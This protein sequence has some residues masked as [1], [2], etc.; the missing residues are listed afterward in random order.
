M[1]D[2]Y[3][4]TYRGYL[5]DHHSPDPPVVNFDK[6]NAEECERFL[7]EANIDH[8][9]VYTKD[10]WGNSYY[11]TKVGKKH[12]ALGERDW[13][14][15]IKP[16]LEK[17]NIEFTAY[18]CFEYDSY[19][20]KAHPEW[21][22]M[23]KDGQK[24]V[25]GMPDN[26]SNA[27]WGMPC[28]SSDYRKYALEQLKEVVRNYHPDSLFIDIFGKSLCYC[29]TC[30]KRY[31]ERFGMEMPETEEDMIRY[32]KDLAAFLD[33]DS[34]ELL[35]EVK[36]ELKAIDPSLA[37]TVNFSSHYRKS[38]RDKLDY[39]YTEPWAGNWLSGAYTRDTSGGRHP[40]LGPGNVSQ[41]FNYQP[42]SIYELAAA[43]IAAQD[44][45]VFMY[46]ES[47]RR[48]GS[49][50]FEEARK[51]GKTYREIEKIEPY[52]G[53]R[54]VHADVCILQSDLSDTLKVTKSIPIRSVSRTKISGKHREALLG[55][56]KLCDYSKISWC[57]VPE[58]DLDLNKMKEFKAVIIPSVAYISEDMAKDLERYTHEGGVVLI[59]GESGLS[60]A[61]G[62]E[63]EEF[64]LKD[65]MGLA[66]ERRNDDYIQNP[67][68]AYIQPKTSPVWKHSSETTPPINGTVLNCQLT[69]PSNM[70]LHG[71]FINPAVG[72]SDTM[73]V[74][75]GSP[76]PGED[77]GYPAIAE[78]VVGD[79]K[80][81]SFCFDFFALINENFIWTKKML[82]DLLLYLFKPSVFLSTEYVNMAEYALYEKTAENEGQQEWIFHELSA[83]ARLTGGDT[84]LIPGGELQI[85]GA[86]I[87]LEK[88]FQVFP[89]KQEI[90]FTVDEENKYHI[91]LNPLRIHRVYQL[92]GK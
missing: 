24:L 12:P 19:I 64:L 88:V 73:W 18:Y 77:T 54:K 50:E 3:K 47:M 56:M 15:E 78:H 25:C 35:D 16:V 57:L 72:L 49:L 75:W 17:L 68:S 86:D 20:T 38:T 29:D 63:R 30:K 80:V 11:D 26:S 84:P 67:W 81:I 44:C 2:K 46:S 8:V 92:I 6:L 48:D 53:N 66:L 87:A 41:I 1:S 28:M 60:D 58:L 23:T 82:T 69:D 27:K 32:N 40:Q 43:E 70:V 85:D 62:K 91:P 55:A 45:H 39:M 10:H 59:S 90:A 51:I 21:S 71:T 74:N 33:D 13:I 83:C 31:R 5:C 34:E 65:L 52:L 22:C 9:M 36:A 42:D 76:L 89:E 79:G 14:A 4:Y 37:I 7:K 61:D